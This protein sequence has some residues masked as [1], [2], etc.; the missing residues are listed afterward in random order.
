VNNRW[1]SEL[2]SFSRK[3]R[4]G[5]LVLL[6]VVFGLIVI[7]MVI[8]L[9]ISSD[10]TNFS[11]WEAEV[12]DYLVK[13]ENKITGS[14]ALHLVP[15]YYRFCRFNQYGTAFKGYLKLDEIPGERGK[16]QG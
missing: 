1:I 11:A 15:Q 4:A 8:P 9:F 13:T 7:G 12:N 3:E 16:F 2:F 6:C 10:K 14:K 5:I